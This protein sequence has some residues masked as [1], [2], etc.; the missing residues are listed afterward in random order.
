[1]GFY[2]ELYYIFKNDIILIAMIVRYKNQN[3]ITEI[4]SFTSII[5]C[6]GRFLGYPIQRIIRLTHRLSLI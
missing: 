3:Y 1:M 4:Y 6:T 5:L 2:I